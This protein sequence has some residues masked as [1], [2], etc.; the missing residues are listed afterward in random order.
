MEF[1]VNR[2]IA[3]MVRVWFLKSKPVNVPTRGVISESS[4]RDQRGL[5]FHRAPNIYVWPKT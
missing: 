5:M 1:V 2:C 4:G 3:V